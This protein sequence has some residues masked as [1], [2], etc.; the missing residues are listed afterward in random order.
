MTERTGMAC[1]GGETVSVRLSCC[2]R[3]Q[4]P[5]SS[6]MAGRLCPAK[7]NLLYRACSRLQIE[8]C[9]KQ[10]LHDSVN[11]GWT[12]LLQ[13]TQLLTSQFSRDY[14]QSR[15]TPEVP[16]TEKTL[17]CWYSDLSTVH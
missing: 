9:S 7:M 3:N 12:R 15:L 6:K 16:A 11:A 4:V 14:F 2:F 17:C 13:I 5:M 1:D 10:C 8:L